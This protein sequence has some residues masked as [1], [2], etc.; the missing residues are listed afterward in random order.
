MQKY[1]CG[2]EVAC[3]PALLMQNNLSRY[4][5]INVQFF[6]EL[7]KYYTTK[8]VPSCGSLETT[9]NACK[10]YLTLY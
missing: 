1:I 5:T 4:I 9:H 7:P 8:Y 10:T 2:V 3:L 6:S